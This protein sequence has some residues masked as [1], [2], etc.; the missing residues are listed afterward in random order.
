MKGDPCVDKEQERDYGIAVMIVQKIYQLPKKKHV[1][2][3]PIDVVR[4]IFISFYTL[5]YIS[6]MGNPKCS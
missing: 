2:T 1:P 6:Y 5:G 4:I 3:K